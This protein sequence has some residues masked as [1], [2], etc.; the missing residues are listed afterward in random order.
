M[1]KRIRNF[2]KAI[3]RASKGFIRGQ[4]PYQA[5]A[6][7]YATLLAIVPFIGVLV[8]LLS[9]FPSIYIELFNETQ[10]YIFQNYLPTSGD[11][12]RRYLNA[13]VVNAGK[14]PIFSFIFLFVVVGLLIS[15]IERAINNIWGLPAKKKNYTEIFF[16]W[17]LLIMLPIFIGVSVVGTTYIFSLPWLANIKIGL[18]AAFTLVINIILFSLLYIMLPHC[19]VKWRVGFTG[20]LIAAL[21]FELFKTLFAYYLK[22]YPSYE[23]IYGLMATI[24]ILLVWIYISWLVILYGAIVT[25]ALSHMKND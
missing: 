22:H 15:T 5:S 25:C 6:L 18:F 20:G 12:I 19:H 16:Y 8:F 17:L 11:I 24:P 2:I 23:L 3:T 9:F 10:D 21:L 7:A 13:F 1:K 14:L 4:S